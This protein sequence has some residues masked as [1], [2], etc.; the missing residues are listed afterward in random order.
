MTSAPTRRDETK[1]NEKDVVDGAREADGAVVG[2]PALT[3]LYLAI[4]ANK[5]ITARW[6]EQPAPLT[7]SMAHQLADELQRTAADPLGV[8][9]S[10][11]RQCE[12]SKLSRPPK[13]VNY[14]RAGI[15]ADL[16][17]AA[18]RA[19]VASSGEQAPAVERR[20]MNRGPVMF[21][22]VL[23]LVE[24]RIVPGQS[25][26]RFIRREKVAALGSDVL[27]AY[28]ATGGAEKFLNTPKD[29]RSFLMRDFAQLLEG[30]SH[31]AAS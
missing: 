24:T 12:E 10:I 27:R 17:R 4:W 16:E 11:Y 30:M 23:E 22:K 19:L 13:A 3:A 26:G 14:F 18:T 31:D 5:A 1:R 28:D 20:P 7:P 15:L 21:A 9:A 8:K 6:G 29:K 25:D 2:E